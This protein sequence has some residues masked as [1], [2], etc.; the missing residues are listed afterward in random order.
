MNKTFKNAK[1]LS[2]VEGDA[3]AEYIL[4]VFNVMATETLET[5]KD[6]KK[7]CNGY[8]TCRSLDEAQK[9]AI[10]VHVRNRMERK[11]TNHLVFDAL[12]I[13]LLSGRYEIYDE[14]DLAKYL[15]GKDS[16]AFEVF[17]AFEEMTEIWSHSLDLEAL[18][19]YLGKGKIGKMVMD[20][21][22]FDDSLVYDGL[23]CD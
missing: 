1:N 22:E 3:S 11:Y 17:D 10:R 12:D 18:D 21:E 23:E 4:S 20:S 15:Y 16:D 7:A 14:K 19:R 5:M 6:I 8:V 2:R 13:A 9:K